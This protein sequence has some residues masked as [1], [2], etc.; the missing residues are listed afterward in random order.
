FCSSEKDIL[1]DIELCP[2]FGE[3]KTITVLD[4]NDE[5][6]T[7]DITIKLKKVLNN[8]NYAK[9]MLKS[10]YKDLKKIKRI[11]CINNECSTEKIENKDSFIFLLI[12]LYSN[13]SRVLT[14]A[15]STT[16]KDPQKAIPT[17]L[18]SASLT[19]TLF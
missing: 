1:V 16:L 14:S 2:K 15:N 7:F 6:K 18:I 19:G 12:I 3:A 10:N 9:D 4:E 13:L 8:N 17:G 11:N 5:T